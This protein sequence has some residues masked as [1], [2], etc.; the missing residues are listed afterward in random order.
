MSWKSWLQLLYYLPAPES[1]MHKSSTFRRTTSKKF[2]GP[3]TP[4]PQFLTSLRLWRISVLCSAAYVHFGMCLFFRF[5]WWPTNEGV[6]KGPRK[7]SYATAIAVCS[8][9]VTVSVSH[10]SWCELQPATLIV[11]YIC[12]SD[13]QSYWICAKNYGTLDDEC[14]H[15]LLLP[16]PPSM[17]SCDN[18]I[19]NVNEKL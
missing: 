4:H 6:H 16:L 13:I 11:E 7:P 17:N 10:R 1:R 14:R 12:G 9:A 15:F 19:V 5:S 2:S 18:D 8:G 3:Q